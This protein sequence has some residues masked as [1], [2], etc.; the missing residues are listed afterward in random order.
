MTYSFRNLGFRILVPVVGILLVT[1]CSSQKSTETTATVRKIAAGQQFSGFLKD[2]ANLK[3]SPVLEGKALTYVSTDANKNLHKYIAVIVDPVEVY[4]ATDANDAKLPEKSRVAAADYFHN[5]LTK[6][7]SSAYPI[8]MEKGPLVLRL[9]AALIGVDVG[10]AVA[11]ADK[12]AEAGEALENAV[13]IGKVTTEMELVD[14]ETGERIAAMVDQETLGEG[15]EI[16]S[17]SFSKQERW[18]AAREAFDEWAHRVR[19]FL[20]ASNE[21]SPEDAK[22]ALESY[23]PYS[24][25]P[26]N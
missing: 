14:S 20:D 19:Y 5:A 15:A 4:L 24:A 11:A 16:G 22:R 13:N 18:A 7:V 23:R 21:L 26:G 12:P 8:A 6:A 9:R 3:P 1:G 10:G 17:L 2:Y 25:Q